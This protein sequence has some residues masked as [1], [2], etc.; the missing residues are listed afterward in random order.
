MFFPEWLHRYR[1][2]LLRLLNNPNRQIKSELFVISGDVEHSGILK[3]L[4]VMSTNLYFGEAHDLVVNSNSMFRGTYRNTLV[5][6]HFEQE[7]SVNHFNYFK[8]KTSQDALLA[9]LTDPQR[10]KHFTRLLVQQPIFL[11]YTNVV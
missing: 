6:E 2:L 3:S 5:K 9:A 10:L 8:N 1:A 7:A 4:L 11:L